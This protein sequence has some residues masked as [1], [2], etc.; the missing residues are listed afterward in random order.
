MYVDSSS[1]PQP[2]AKRRWI[3]A[4]IGLTLA[5]LFLG[6][7]LNLLFSQSSLLAKAGLMLLGISAVYLAQILRPHRRLG[8]RSWRLALLGQGAGVV[9]L[10]LLW[11]SFLS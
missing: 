2:T 5:G 11:L 4:E 7:V 3:S 9:G 8:R 1:T 6:L 10:L